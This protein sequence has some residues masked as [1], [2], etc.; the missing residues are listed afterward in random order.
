MFQPTAAKSPDPPAAKRRIIVS[1][2][3]AQDTGETE[4]LN[5]LS[6]GLRFADFALAHTTVDGTALS[7]DTFLT[8]FR[9]L[10]GSA[11]ISSL[12]PTC[13]ETT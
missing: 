7:D 6:F 2:R 4:P 1:R 5:P 11:G 8:V 9:H 10:M 3:H 12:S 13:M